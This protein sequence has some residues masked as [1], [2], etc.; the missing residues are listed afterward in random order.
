MESVVTVPLPESG[1]PTVHDAALSETVDGTSTY[2][3]Q[4]F[5]GFTNPTASSTACESAMSRRPR[6]SQVSPAARV[7]DTRLTDGKV[8]PNE[9]RVVDLGGPGFARGAIINVIVTGTEGDGYVA[10]VPADTH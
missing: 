1:S 10:V 5:V 4:F 3:L 9:E 7:L 6:P 2:N 8:S